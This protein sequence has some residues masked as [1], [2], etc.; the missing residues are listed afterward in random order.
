MA[1]LREATT[2]PE[3]G[4]IVS[5]PSTLETELTVVPP[6]LIQP[7]LMAKHPPE[8]S[9]PPA[10]VEVALLRET[11]LRTVVVPRRAWM[12]EASIDPPVT[13]SPFD[14]ASPTAEIPPAKVEVPVPITARL[15]VVALEVVALRAVKFWRVVELVTVSVPGKT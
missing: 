10:K 2:A 15:V 9:M 13:M 1:R 4:E 8:R 6:M 14:D 12:F 11:M 5:V 3:L 7:P